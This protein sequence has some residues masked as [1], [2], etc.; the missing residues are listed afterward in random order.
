MT[1]IDAGRFNDFEHRGWA[2]NSAD[3]YDRVFGPVTGRVIDDLLDAAGVGTSTR[4]LDVATGPGYVAARAHAR[5]ARV[6]GVDLS[7]AMLEMARRAHPQIEFRRADAEDL[8]FGDG[9]FDAAVAN[10]G[11]LHVGRPEIVVA[12]MARVL[13]PGGRAGLTVWNSPEHCRL[14]S[15]VPDAV[16][17]AGATPSAEIPPGPDF[18]RFAADAEFGRLLASAGLAE[19]RVTKIDFLHVVPSADHLWSGM[20]DGSVRTRA[21]LRLQTDET[22]QR[23]RVQFDRQLEGYRRPEGLVVPVSVKLA[24]G[25]KS[26]G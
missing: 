6:V 4:L 2:E 1:E 9:S 5:G 23:I 26:G 11:L 18:F 21:L 12:E 15:L 3:A 8:G 13:A 7:P 10:F 19:V 22:L 17:A 20:L 24:C 16:A 25:R 14:F